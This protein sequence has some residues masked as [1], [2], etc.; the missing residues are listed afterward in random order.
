MVLLVV[1][2]VLVVGAA[3]ALV[4]GK[5]G[6][7]AV[8][9][10]AADDPVATSPFEALPDGPVDADDVGKVRFDMTLRGYRMTQV[11]EVID[12]LRTEIADRDSELRRLR[13]H[14]AQ[15]TEPAED[16]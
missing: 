3:V 2:L 16:D 4:L 15:P 7:R 6:G 9:V 5:V 8:P 10:D 13:G 1:L 12:R 11:D 14:L